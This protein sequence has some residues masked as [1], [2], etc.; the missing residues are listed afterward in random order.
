MKNLKIKKLLFL[1]VFGFAILLVGCEGK[2]FTVSFDYDNGQQVE[3]KTF[4]VKSGV[5]YPE[6]TKEGYT[7]VEWKN[8]GKGDVNAPQ[9]GATYSLKA[10][11][12]INEY[13][14]KFVNDDDTVLMEG[15]ASYGEMP[16]APTEVT[17][18]G[19][20]EKAYVFAG[21]DK[22][23]T[24]LKED[25][26]YKATYREENAKYKI[27]FVNYDDSLIK[28][29]TVAYGEMPSAPTTVLKASTD[30]FKYTFDGWDK[31]VAIVTGDATYKAKFIAEKNSNS[32]LSSFFMMKKSRAIPA[33]TAAVDPIR[34]PIITHSFFV[35]RF[36]K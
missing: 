19:T 27:R 31:E 30:E 5:E 9:E 35:E 18:V 8:V 14:Y 4:N 12:K 13:T 22:A 21:W 1:I 7:F 16:V 6:A 15:K 33:M 28:E 34:I 29:Q 20:A 26:I 23:V 10:I 17:K 36:K 32:Y 25:V 2:T 11:Y 24:A 3:T